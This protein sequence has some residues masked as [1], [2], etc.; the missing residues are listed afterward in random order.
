MSVACEKL[1]PA[2]RG[3]TGIKGIDSPPVDAGGGP[4]LALALLFP[5]EEDDD[6]SEGYDGYMSQWVG[7][8]RCRS[9]VQLNRRL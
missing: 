4:G 5:D 6:I 9:K 1:Y 7:S 3:L 2:G 8:I